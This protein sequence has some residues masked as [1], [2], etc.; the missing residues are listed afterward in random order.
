MPMKQHL[1]LR[2]RT[3]QSEDLP[4]FKKLKK[5][6]S[7]ATLQRLYGLYKLSF[8]PEHLGYYQENKLKLSK[9]KHLFYR[10]ES[11]SRLKKIFCF[12]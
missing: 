1:L 5:E 4:G 10:P 7:I 2:I 6:L 11:V 9:K 3:L 8:Y 12:M